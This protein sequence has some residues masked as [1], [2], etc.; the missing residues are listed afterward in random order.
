[1]LSGPAKAILMDFDGTSVH[2]ETFWMWI[3]EQSG[4]GTLCKKEY[5]S[6]CDALPYIFGK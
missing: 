2:S 1:M 3:I 5:D 4:T 6:I